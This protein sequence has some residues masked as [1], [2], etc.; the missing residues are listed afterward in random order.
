MA[1]I[2]V[3]ELLSLKT[4]FTIKNCYDT[5]GKEKSVKSLHAHGK[6]LRSM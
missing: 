6:D 2:A 4:D 5:E 1:A 3:K